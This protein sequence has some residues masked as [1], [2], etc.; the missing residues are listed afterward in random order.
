MATTQE[1]LETI[2]AELGITVPVLYRFAR[3]LK[4]AV[5]GTGDRR[6][7]WPLGRVG[8]GKNAADVLGRHLTNL[9]L[10]MFAT[11]PSEAVAVVDALWGWTKGPNIDAEGKVLPDR[12]TPYATL[13][14][15][16]WSLI[17]TLALR[18]DA[19]RSA[20]AEAKS[21]S[22]LCVDLEGGLAFVMDDSTREFH[23]G[24]IFRD[25]GKNPFDEKANRVK[26]IV[27][28]PLPLVV[29]AADLLTDTMAKRGR[30]NPISSGEAQTTVGLKNENAPD[31]PGS[32]AP[33]RTTARHRDNGNR[34][35]NN[36][37]TKAEIAKSQALSLSRGQAAPQHVE[38]RIAP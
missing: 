27:E 9:L 29:V 13:G 18:D 15:F 14:E 25:P 21:A 30:L 7:L 33:T 11:Q 23:P 32:E 16:L 4:E 28:I 17:E 1:A 26:R 31:L 6:D 37:E 5:D 35:L 19:T 34:T 20:F 2:A 10:A 8:G 3:A 12:E 22:R 36:R 24:E 38:E